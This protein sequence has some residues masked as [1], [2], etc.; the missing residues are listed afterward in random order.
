MSRGDNNQREE[1]NINWYS[2]VWNVPTAPKVR[3]LV[4]KALKGALPTGTRLQERH[5]NVETSCKRC[6]I[7]ESIPH[8]FFQCTVAQE[9]WAQAPF[10]QNID[11]SGKIDFK[12]HWDVVRELTCLPPSGISTTAL[13]PWILWS[14]WVSRNKLIFDAHSFPATEILT[15]A[16]AAAREWQNGQ[17]KAPQ[18]QRT[19]DLSPVNVENTILM[20]SDAS[21]KGDRNV[22]GLG[23]VI[24]GENGPIKFS[25]V[26]EHVSTPLMAESI[27]MRAALVK[28]KEMGVH[29]IR[30][31]ADSKQLIACIR[32]E[33]PMPE[34][35]GIV[36]DI[37]A[38]ASEFETISFGWIS[39][40]ENVIA[41]GLAKQ[42]VVVNED[43]N[44][45][46]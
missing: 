27:A 41:D 42:C 23:W 40:L 6:G 9:V 8:L 3:M 13:A 12:E 32:N 28:C 1:A 2:S 7:Q 34:I 37:V 16:I 38:L 35:Y 24:Y 31:E 43:V 39:R 36:S 45:L 30:C 33:E 22:A 44:S 4:W 11:F 18:K 21:W 17:V 15:N 46:T 26:E 25:A 14:L 19:T 20:R 10:T 5:M 29:R